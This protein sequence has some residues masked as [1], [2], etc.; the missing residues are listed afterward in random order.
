MLNEIALIGLAMQL[1]T[2]PTTNSVSV[3]NQLEPSDKV[4]VQVF[5][6]EQDLLPAKL[7]ALVKGAALSKTDGPQPTSESSMEDIAAPQPCS[8]SSGTAAD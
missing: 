5:V 1:A 2:N 8:E 7:E 3:Y 4:K 6:N